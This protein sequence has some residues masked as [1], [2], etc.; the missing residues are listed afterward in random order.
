MAQKDMKKATHEEL[1]DEVE[2]MAQIAGKSMQVSVVSNRTE[3]FSYYF[4]HGN[5][6]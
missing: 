1:L 4:S 2:N 6:D 5:A 3:D